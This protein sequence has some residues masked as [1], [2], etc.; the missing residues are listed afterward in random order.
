MPKTEGAGDQEGEFKRVS[1]ANVDSTL[2]NQFCQWVVQKYGKL[3]GKIGEAFNEMLKQFVEGNIPKPD[4]GEAVE[5]AK[6]ILQMISE[7][8]DWDDLKLGAVQLLQE[9]K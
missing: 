2:W 4:S 1:I 3:Q 8:Q 7:A 6:S 5:V 9:L